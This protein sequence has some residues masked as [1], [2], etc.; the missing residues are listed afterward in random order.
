[1]KL[2]IDE[3]GTWHPPGT[4]LG[5]QYLLS[6]TVTLRDA[7]HAALNLDI[8]NRH[9][10][11]IAMANIAQTINCLDSLFLARGGR[12]VRTPVYWV[13]E[14]YR[15]HM[16]ARLVPATVRAP[17][18]RL[19]GSASLA[20][21]RLTLTM[22][23]SSLDAGVQAAVEF[24]GAVAREARARVLTHPDMRAANTFDTEDAVRPQPLAVALAAGRAT[25]KIPKQS[26]VAL[27]VALA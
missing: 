27:E 15:P 26:V 14:L 17:A 19:S 1:V 21:N 16:G 25:I 18:A 4:E 6:Q 20:G 11:K 5:P 10:D 8:F 3:W 13:Y 22:V 9:A 7:L 23:N 12:Y 2:V 24:G